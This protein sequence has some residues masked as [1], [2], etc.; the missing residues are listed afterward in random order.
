MTRDAI[1]YFADDAAPFSNFISIER[2]A[3]CKKSGKPE[4]RDHQV[5]A[6]GEKRER[7]DRDQQRDIKSALVIAYKDTAPMKTGSDLFAPRHSQIDSEDE[8]YSPRKYEPRV[9]ENSSPPAHRYHPTNGDRKTERSHC[10]PEPYENP[11]N[12]RPSHASPPQIPVKCN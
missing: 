1:Y 7:I 11:S 10:N 3:S 2:D 9:I 6:L 5:L 4:E 8:T 12:I